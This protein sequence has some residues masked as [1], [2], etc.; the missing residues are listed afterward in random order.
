M[1]FFWKARLAFGVVLGPADACGPEDLLDE[2]VHPVGLSFHG[3]LGKHSVDRV[4]QVA[5]E[6]IDDAFAGLVDLGLVSR[7]L[8]QVLDE[9]EQ[10]PGLAQLQQV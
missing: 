9:L 4:A 7:V 6:G 5:E 8:G 10:H 2:G 3:D 1:R